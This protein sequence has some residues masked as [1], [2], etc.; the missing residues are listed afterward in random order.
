MP[1]ELT[2]SS[3]REL[4]KA[5][6]QYVSCPELNDVLYLQ[7]KGILRIQSLEAYTGVTTLYLEGNAITQIEGLAALTV[8]RCLYLGRNLVSRIQGLGALTNLDTLDLRD[9]RISRVDGLDG[10]PNLRTLILSGNKLATADDLSGLSAVTASL[11]CLDVARNRLEGED[12]LRALLEL[13]GLALLAAAGNPICGGTQWVQHLGR[14][15]W[16][17]HVG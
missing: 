14:G 16:L 6:K 3:L 12:A 8:L 2:P 15:R 5:H 4:C 10:L 1:L 13:R 9:N 17:E 11:T 7:C